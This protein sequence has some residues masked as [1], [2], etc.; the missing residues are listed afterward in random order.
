MESVDTNL[1]VQDR[2]PSLIEAVERQRAVQREEHVA[3]V[4]RLRRTLLIGIAVWF[5]FALVDLLVDRRLHVGRPW[6]FVGLRLVEVAVYVPAFVVLRRGAAVSRRMLNAIDLACFT[7]ASTLVSVMCLSIG[8]LSSPYGPGVCLVL[9]ARTVMSNEP[10]RRGVFMN[11]APALAYPLVL[12]G[13]L[14]FDPEIAAQLRDPRA[15]TIFGLHLAYVFGTYALMVFCGHVTWSL[16]Q[17]IFET[18]SI[19]KYKLKERLGEGA[20]GEVWLA[21]HAALKRDV[22][23]KILRRDP[24]RDTGSVSR[25][26]REVRA[27]AELTHPNT[28]RVYDYGVTDD[29]LQYYA[30]E[31]LSGVTLAEL[32]DREGPLAPARAIH[33]VD[34]ASRALAEAHAHGIVHRDI[35]PENL[36]V[37]SLGG[38]HDFLKVLDFGIARIAGGDFGATVTNAG[39][40]LGTPAYLSPE[41]AAGKQ[42][43]ARSDVYAL[44]GV[45]YFVLC[46]RP[47]FESDNLGELLLSHVNV[48][49]ELPSAKLGRPLP[50]DLEQLTMRCLEKDPAVRFASAAELSVALAA[51]ESA[52]SW[53]AAE[54]AVRV[55]ATSP[56]P[57]TTS[58]LDETLDRPIAAVS[59]SS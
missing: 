21:Y 27:T 22:A 40:V 57:R 9:V 23:I 54:K 35:K 20:M 49:P 5:G 25:F 53:I 4:L 30:M 48:R 45:L 6:Y 2:A 15:T 8:G 3:D 51:C 52:G 43:D 34:Q 17:Q 26:E 7:V 55:R 13:A 47:P 31:A 39:F 1:A 37:A 24:T 56:P 42:A 14:A 46:G 59:S 33:F 10:W 38:E 19:G 36:F 11:A 58:E 16:R 41:V 28:V 29:G 12:F 18:R 32:V 44:G 50:T